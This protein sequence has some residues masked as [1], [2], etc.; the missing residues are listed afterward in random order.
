M[1]SDYGCTAPGLDS[2]LFS[3]S[4]LDGWAGIWLDREERIGRAEPLPLVITNHHRFAA[5]ERPTCSDVQ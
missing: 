3:V 5:K 1:S 4:Q 2:L